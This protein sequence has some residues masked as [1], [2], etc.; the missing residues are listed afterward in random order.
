MT[1]PRVAPALGTY[2]PPPSANRPAPREPDAPRPSIWPSWRDP[3]VP[4]AAILTAYLVMGTTWLGFNRT[5]GQIVT[6]VALG[7][8]LDMALH[9]MLKKREL[10]V[11]L[12]AYISSLSLAI[13]L[14][15]AHDYALL[16]LPV[17][18]TIGSKYLFTVDGR[19]HF[20]PSLF[21]VAMTLLFTGELITAAPAY[22][23][24]GTLA[25][26][27][28]VI[29]LAAAGFVFRIGRGWLIASFLVTYALQ[30]GLRAWLMRAHM[31]PEML[32][33]GTLTSPPFFIF[34]FFMITD[35][36]TSPAGRGAQIGVG[37]A[38]ALVDLVL[39]KY[40]SVFTFF[41]AAFLVAAVRFLWMHAAAARRDG[42]R[43]R[44]THHLLTRRM[45]R[46]AGVLGGLAVIGGSSYA[47][48]IRPHVGLHEPGFRLVEVPPSSSGLDVTMDPT[49]YDLVDP[50]LRHI[51]KWLLSVGASVQV[52]DVDGD[53]AQDAVITSPLAVPAERI[54]LLRNRG[55]M[56]FERVA[57]P[58]LDA[59][60]GDPA[61]HGLVSGALFV[62]HD[63][64]GDQDM[65]VLVS[66]GAPRLL[67]NL[68]AES[69]TAHFMDV[70]EAA[71]MPAY[72]ISVAANIL[73]Y[74]R[75][76]WPDILIGNVLSLTL[77]EYAES[78]RLNIF[79]LPQPK[80]R[81]DR[82]MF[83]FMHDGWHDANNGGLNVLL[84]NR[85]DGT[86]ETMD[87]AAMGMPESHW[88]LAIGTGD[89]NG[90]GWTDLY[91]ASD[92][93]RDD[94]YLNEQGARFRRVSG[95][96]FSEIGL[97]TYKGM[98]SSVADFDRD[99]RLDV[100]V[101]NVH[102]ALQ[103]EGS[104]L[105]M[106]RTTGVDAVPAFRDEA[107][108]RGALNER[109]FG[110]GAGVGDLQNDGWTDIIQANGMVDDRLD[111][112]AEGCP[113]YWYV[114]HKLMQAPRAIHV[115]ADMWGDIRGRCIYPNE[116]RRVYVNRGADARPQFVDMAA[117]AGLTARDNSRGV[118]LAD[119]DSD[120]R[121]DALITNQHAAPTLLRNAPVG[122]DGVLDRTG[123]GVRGAEAQANAWV[124]LT[125]VGDGRSC[126]RDAIGSTVTAMLPGQ[127]ALVRE[128]QRANGFSAAGDQRV[129]IG[130]GRWSGNVPIA[131]RWCG[132][133]TTNLALAP[134]RYHVIRQ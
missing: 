78:T 92:F 95:R 40:E 34:T 54:L 10:I 29:M 14:N 48:V 117:A 20:N 74:D 47:E 65:L 107:S 46:V 43:H 77:R 118:A 120:G 79:R 61:T 22:Q 63:N 106:N 102:H 35:P 100:Y 53:G 131:I 44:I 55:G 101:S 2:A 76:G 24:G 128:V 116:A 72:A 28:F 89:F 119:F 6:I 109:R 83:A 134:G 87:A 90:D 69:G 103:A 104:L 8:T 19:H 39:H 97:D 11:P 123:P 115:Y 36:R 129:H 41:Y 121:L 42:I 126:S 58:A 67:K 93:G 60:A 33:L 59:F 25:M 80:H 57:V 133:D 52:A 73:D 114:N 75:D 113:D 125:L 9:W 122:Q 56:R 88:T 86:F 84:R 15:Y 66:F 51:G 98:N 82:R 38:I 7:C 17:F 62:D 31:P 96:M 45:A 18:L 4:F 23:W 26:S 13:L 124:G 132:G 91:L 16:A 111:R 37:V 64:D 1:L 5:P 108:S 110:W 81:G 99:G 27:A 3:R 112:R 71:G 130:L 21:G 105:W 68:L 70:S 32:F 49:A 50:R 30:T 94:L 85:G 127:P 12:S